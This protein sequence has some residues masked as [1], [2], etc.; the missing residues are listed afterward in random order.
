M[1]CYVG[2]NINAFSTK[3]NKFEKKCPEPKPE[4]VSTTLTVQ[5]YLKFCEFILQLAQG[6][7]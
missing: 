4:A 1:W 7:Q 2:A 3:Q 5:I 6:F